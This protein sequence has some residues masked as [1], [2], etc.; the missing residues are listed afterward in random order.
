MTFRTY[1]T[2]RAMRDVKS[3]IKAQD[4]NVSVNTK[5]NAIGDDVIE[6]TGSK[7]EILVLREVFNMIH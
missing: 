4:L 5:T 7:E 3:I 2:S 1:L 6:V